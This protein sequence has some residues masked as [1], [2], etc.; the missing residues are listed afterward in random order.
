MST[1]YFYPDVIV[2]ED[3]KSSEWLI[4]QTQAL[5]TGLPG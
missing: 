3:V 4:Y 1:Y 5:Y 2:F